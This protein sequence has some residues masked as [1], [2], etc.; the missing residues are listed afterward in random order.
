MCDDCGDET[1]EEVVPGTVWTDTGAGNLHWTDLPIMVFKIIEEVG[2]TVYR[3]GEFAGGLF[4]AHANQRGR[5]L[6]VAQEMHDSIE[7][8]TGER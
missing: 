8:I 3:L 7:R 1:E 6:A 2:K 4:K 5:R